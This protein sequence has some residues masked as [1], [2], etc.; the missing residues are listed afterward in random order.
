MAIKFKWSD[1]PKTDTEISEIMSAAMA[2]LR[3]A[4]PN[5]PIMTII[6]FPTGDEDSTYICSGA[7]V[8]P[9]QQYVMLSFA[10][11]GTQRAPENTT[12]N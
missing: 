2:A 8:G 4:A 12:L 7:N 11:G 5:L 10:L 3:K 6:A 9:E 1:D